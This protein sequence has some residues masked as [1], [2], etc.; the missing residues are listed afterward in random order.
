VRAGGPGVGVGGWVSLGGQEAGLK[1]LFAAAGGYECV[2]AAR[3][4]RR[5]DNR[6][7]GRRLHRCWIHG[8]FR[9]VAPGPDGPEAAAAAASGRDVNL[10]FPA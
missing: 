1:R 2:S 10:K 6:R 7:Q 8:R 4:R 5:M 3:E 9:A